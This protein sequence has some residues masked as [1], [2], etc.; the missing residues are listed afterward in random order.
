[1]ALTIPSIG[2]GGLGDSIPEKTEVVLLLGLA[3]TPLLEGSLVLQRERQRHAPVGFK[4]C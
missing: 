1:M 3:N 4:V 2:H